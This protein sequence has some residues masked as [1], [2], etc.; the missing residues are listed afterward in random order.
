[1]PPVADKMD[2]GDQCEWRNY[3]D[4]FRPVRERLGTRPLQSITKADIED[5]M[6]WMLTAGRR[7]QAAGAA[8]S[9][10][11]GYRA[12]RPGS[13]WDG[14]PRPWRWQSWRAS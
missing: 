6:D 2:R 13:P 14:S 7:P 10:E 1:V 4:A 3:E 12:G 8:A 11:P 5:L 9:R